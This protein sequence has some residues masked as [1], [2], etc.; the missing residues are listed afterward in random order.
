MSQTPKIGTDRA[1]QISTKASRLLT[2]SHG[3]FLLSI[4]K[5]VTSVLPG[6]LGLACEQ[7][8]T[9]IF[10]GASLFLQVTSQTEA[11]TVSDYTWDM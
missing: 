10:L 5:P 6:Q 9:V 1:W 8:E 7:E 4:S 11:C 3:L 2:I